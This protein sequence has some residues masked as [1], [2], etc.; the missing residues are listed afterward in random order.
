MELTL[1][2]ALKSRKVRNINGYY[3]YE[4]LVNYVRKK[5]KS[6]LDIPLFKIDVALTKA[7]ERGEIDGVGCIAL[8]SIDKSEQ[9]PVFLVKQELCESLYYTEFKGREL[10]LHRPF[11]KKGIV[12]MPKL[13]NN[14]KPE[15]A[16]YTFMIEEEVLYIDGID[17]IGGGFGGFIRLNTCDIPIDLSKKDINFI[18]N[19]FLYQ[20]SIKDKEPSSTELTA[21]PR[22]FGSAKNTNQKQIITPRMIGADYKPKTIRQESTG[23][24][25]SPTTHWRSGHWRQQLIGKKENPDHKTI[26]IEPVLVN[27]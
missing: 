8:R 5:G 18:C 22:G 26:W 3:P 6:A 20:Q 14:Q 13:V 12:L 4:H 27:G 7:L 10:F 19:L 23:T 16:I 11:T 2:Q 15:I 25:A 24:H 17:P 1:R 21:I 9:Y